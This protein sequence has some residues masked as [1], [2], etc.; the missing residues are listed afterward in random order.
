MTT[1]ALEK[2]GR[3]LRLGLV[4]GGGAAL[5]GPV[6]RIAARL[7]DCF[8]LVAG[9]LSSNREKALAEAA[10]LGLPRGYADVPAM[11]AAEAARPDGIDAVAIM[12]PNDDHHASAAAALDAGL[13]VICDK[14][15]TNDLA[16][17][18]DLVARAKTRARLL[19]VTHNYSGYP[20]VREA[21]AAIAASELGPLRVV[22]A[23]YV[24]GSLGTRVEQN[25]EKIAD[26]L[27]WRLDPARGGLSHVLGDIGT[28][29]HQLA[30]YVCGRRI[31]AVLADVGA[32][33]PGR[34]AHDTAS[35]IVRLE[36]GVR[37]VFFV[38]KAATGAENSMSIE[39]Y[40][41]V[42]GVSWNQAA[43][44]E[45]RVMRNASPAEI[46]TRGLPTLHPLARAAARLPAGH[47]EAFFE[48]FAN[49]YRD[50]AELVAARR[51]GIAPDPLATTIPKA[52]DGAD[53][54]AF[55]EAC[56][57]STRQGKWIDV[58]RI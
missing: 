45:L 50:F 27:K 5:I 52:G 20:M 49:L 3:R 14:P 24:Q 34:L 17:S 9:V 21:R 22:H 42:G 58:P 57:E 12:T 46:R 28:H 55:V 51:I 33:I 7:D 36:G 15:L 43:A 18:L 41:E 8:E 40:G 13:D 4:G 26:R 30:T 37:G 31:E 38:T 39:A 47:P 48:A 25:P 1:P 44:N 32:V 6:H 56:L 16:S 11:L 23:A 10:R 19:C 35:V 53:G 54:I 2:L 29:V